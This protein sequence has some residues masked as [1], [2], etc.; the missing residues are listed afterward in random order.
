[1][2]QLIVGLGNPDPEYLSSPH[3][4]G[5]LYTDALVEQNE[6]KRGYKDLWEEQKIDGAIVIRPL[7]YMNKSGEAVKEAAKKHNIKPENILVIHD[8]LD[9]ELGRVKMTFDRSS[10]MHKGV[11]SI[12]KQLKTQKFWR[13]R[14]GITPKKKP[15]SRQMKD[16]LLKKMSAPQKKSLMKNEKKIV[17]GV[18][19][20]TQDHARGMQIINTK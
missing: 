18:L 1:M 6:W 4:A 17:D 11:E 10:A 2:K 13:L 8:D 3:N 9:I 14:V 15:G 5:F 20:W 19:E 16:F 7:T 12:I